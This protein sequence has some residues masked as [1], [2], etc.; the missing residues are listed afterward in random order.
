MRRA[1]FAP[2]AALWLLALVT[3]AR[4][5]LA[6]DARAVVDRYVEATG[7]RAALDAERATHARGRIETIKLKGSIEQ[8]TQVPD[9]LVTRIQLGSLRMRSGTD[10]RTAWTTDLNSKRV[11]VLEGPELEKFQSDAWFENEMWA[12]EGQGGGKV[13][14]VVTSFRQNETFHTLDVTPPVGPPRRL[15]FSG[16]TGLLTRYSER[17]DQHESAMFLSEYRTLRGRKRATLQ[18]GVDQTWAFAY[19]D[20]PV[21]RVLLDSMSVTDPDSAFFSPPASQDGVVTWL[22]TKGIARVGFRYGSRYVWIKASING[23][24]PADF[25]LDTGA[26]GMAIDRDYAQKIGLVKEGR[27][28]VQ[29]MGGGDAAAFAR[30]R[31]IRVTGADGDGVELGDFKASVLDLGEGHE[32]VLWRKMAGLIGY[33]FLGRFVVEIDYDKKIV[34]FREPKDYTYQGEGAGI[35]MKLMMGIPIVTVGFDHGCSGQFLVDAGNS[36]GLIVHG[37]LVKNCAVFS[38]VADRKQVKIYGGGI[39]GGF[40]SWLCRLDTLRIGPFSILEPIA[41]LSLSTHGMVGSEDYG[42]NIGSGVLE[43]FKCTFDYARRK[44][45]LEPGAAYHERD[46]Y[47]RMGA[48]LLRNHERVVAWGVVHGSPADEAGLKDEDEVVEI[49]GRAA[50]SFT[51]EELDRLFVDGKIGSKH[52]LKVLR[53]LKPTTVTLTLQDVI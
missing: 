25:L 6:P 31:S 22:K 14:Y 29:G 8:W 4:A 33:D 36:F 3:P 41:G 18:D 5:S 32:A 47:S 19:D 35:D 13:L 37:S 30:V 39:G 27:F 45:Y 34:T 16:K 23:L 17:S 53:D 9:R 12:R 49:D 2:F 28:G 46:R 52:T 26:S 42:G 48:Y 15:V 38:R 24:P 11:R 50:K 44:L 40:Q 51:P 20:A 21:N 1:S 7:G 10:G 43:R